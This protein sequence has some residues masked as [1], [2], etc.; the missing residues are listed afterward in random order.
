M[1]HTTINIRTC[2]QS[3]QSMKVYILC[4]GTRN[5]WYVIAIYVITVK[6]WNK[7]CIKNHP[8]YWRD[9]QGFPWQCC[10]A[11]DATQAFVGQPIQNIYIYMYLRLIEAPDHH[12]AHRRRRP[13]PVGMWEKNRTNF[14][15]LTIHDFESGSWTCSP[16]S[17]WPSS[18]VSTTSLLGFLGFL[19]AVLPSAFRFAAARPQSHAEFGMRLK[20]DRQLLQCDNYI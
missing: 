10:N 6:D 5:C 9:C 2:L 18:F 4:I 13:I 1:D 7:R 14:I 3:Q 19:A 20:W 17:S 15:K 12:M 16:A 8:L 11:Q